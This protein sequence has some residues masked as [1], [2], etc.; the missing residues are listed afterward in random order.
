MSFGST[1]RIIDLPS[2]RYDSEISIE[3]T[4]LHRRSHRHFIS[5]SISIEELSQLLWAAYGI[6]QSV[7]DDSAFKGNLKTTPSAGATYPLE[8]YAIVGLVK[9]IEAGVYRYLPK[10]HKLVNTIDKDIR[11]ELCY[12]SLHQEMIAQAPVS[13]LFNAVNKRSTQHYGKRGRERYVCM[14]AGHAAQNVYLQAEALNLG[15]C[16]IG[17][18]EDD[19]VKKVMQLPLEEEPLYIMSIGRCYK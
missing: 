18:F 14:E 5:E 6:N 2:L 3:K 8:V 13:L 1:T 19:K 10:G 15:T 4:L 17:A 16:A 11:T 9:G 12:A 7:T